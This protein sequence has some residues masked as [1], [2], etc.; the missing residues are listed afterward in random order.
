MG[1]QH[2]P[3]D[4]DEDIIVLFD[5]CPRCDEHSRTLYDLDTPRLKSIGAIVKGERRGLT[6]NENRAAHHLRLAKQI[7]E[8]SGV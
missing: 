4:G 5:G 6:I 2:M 3:H 7:V 1:T 8:R